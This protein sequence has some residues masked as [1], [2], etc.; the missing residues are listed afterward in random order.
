MKSCI[1][2]AALALGTA[3]FAAAQ[4]PNITYI[5]N[6]ASFLPPGLPNSGLAE[7]SIITIFGTNIGPGATASATSFPLR[8]SLG[9]SSVTFTVGGEST[10]GLML[11]TS[12]GQ[13]SA[14]LPSSTPA[15]AGTVTVS[16]NNQTSNALPITVVANNFAMYTLPQNGSGPAV[17]TTP[18][19]H[20]VTL[21]SPAKPGDTL[22]LW[23][24]GLGPYSGDETEPPPALYPI[25]VNAE[26]YVG[27]KSAT[28][29]YQGRAGYAG[30]DQINFIV[31]TGLSGCYVPVVV[32][33]NGITSNFGSVAISSDGSTCSDPA[34]L[35]SSAIS[36]VENNKNLK[37]GFISL[38]KV[39]FNAAVFGTNVT[40]KQDTGDAYFYNF[41]DL[42]LITSRGIS[43]LSSF[44]SCTVLVCTNSDTCIPNSTGLIVPELDAGPAISIDGP[45]GSVTLPKSTTHNGEYHG[46]LGSAVVGTGSDYLQPGNYTASNGSTGGADVKNF[47]ANLTIGQPLTW[48]NPLSSTDTID[49]TKDLTINYSPGGGPNDYVAI[50]GSSTANTSTGDNTVTFVCTEKASAGT[51][52]IPSYVLSAL[53]A[54]GMITIDNI[55]GTGGFLLVG[56]YPLSNTFT[57]PGLDLGFFSETVVNGVNLAY[58]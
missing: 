15:D 4:Q 11:F 32:V 7:G 20:V 34:G 27:D 31:P 17:I 28:I 52:T 23:G 16:F 25:S 36:Q 29:R 40:V 58:K 46:P 38:Q 37:V 53:P 10:Q 54:S 14:V 49:R 55:R 39:S 12:A 50:L 35:P 18:T 24:T 56:N 43:A 30:L 44:S 1:V 22:V 5:S 13:L 41:D 6:S 3:V 57:A 47:T 51:F 26:V 45:S 21:N 8:T 9:G 2:Y 42:A 33:V 19:Y 48:T